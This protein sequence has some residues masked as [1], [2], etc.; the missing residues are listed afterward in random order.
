MMFAVFV[1]AAAQLTPPVVAPRTL[2]DSADRQTLPAYQI[3]CRLSDSRGGTS[4]LKLEQVGGRG[5]RATVEELRALPTWR[6]FVSTPVSLTIV[7]D[8]AGLFENSVV[9]VP[10]SDM[11]ARIEMYRWDSA[12][13]TDSSRMDFRDGNRWVMIRLSDAPEETSG[14]REHAVFAA[15]V[16]RRQAG[17]TLPGA[18][19][20]FCSI[21]SDP[22]QPLSQAEEAEYRARRR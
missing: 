1:A 11:P 14:A 4:H 5:V 15:L 17:R 16:T 2:A 22:Q 7:R 3:D 19:V 9:N 10:T 13:R 8:D 21:D 6:R 20:G 18:H 12:S